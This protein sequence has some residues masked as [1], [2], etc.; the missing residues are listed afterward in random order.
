MASEQ[1][2]PKDVHALIPG[3][4]EYV[5]L[6]DSVDVIKRKDLKMRRL[7]PISEMGPIKSHQSWNWETSHAMLRGIC[8]MLYYCSWRC[9][10][11]FWAKE[12]EWILE[13]GKRTGKKF[14]LRTPER[15]A[16][17]SAPWFWPGKTYLRL[18]LLELQEI[19]LCCWK[20]LNLWQFI[21]AKI[22][23]KYRDGTLGKFSG[24]SRVILASKCGEVVQV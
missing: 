6:N 12:H 24:S 5:V 17:L 10:E 19:C 9:R 21:A 11:R 13:D 15:K 2:P 7:S 1:W 23:N 22:E 16:A 20:Q 4:C 14:F 18:L 8:E 3:N